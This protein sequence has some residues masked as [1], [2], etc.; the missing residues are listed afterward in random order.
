MIKQIIC[1]ILVVIGISTYFLIKNKEELTGANLVDQQY[2]EGQSDS[3]F[4]KPSP[5]KWIFNKNY[6]RGYLLGNSNEK[7]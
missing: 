4:K 7:I 3:R 5:I 1:T 6:R 2:I